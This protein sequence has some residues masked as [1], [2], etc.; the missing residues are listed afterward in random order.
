MEKPFSVFDIA[1]RAMSAQL[2]RLN[3]TASNLANAGSVSGTKEDAFRARRNDLPA[4][5]CTFDDD[6]VSGADL[7]Y[8]RGRKPG[9]DPEIVSR[10]DMHSRTHFRDRASRKHVDMRDATVDW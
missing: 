9:L 6:A 2:V 8:L 10:V 3:T 5:L 4:N 7:A 1:G